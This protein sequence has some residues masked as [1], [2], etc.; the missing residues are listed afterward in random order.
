LNLVCIAMCW[1]SKEFFR[2]SICLI[3]MA[4]VMVYIEDF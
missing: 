4:L 1:S 3:L 2:L